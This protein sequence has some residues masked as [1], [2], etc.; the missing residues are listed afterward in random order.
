MP[1][2]IVHFDIY[3]PQESA[4]H[5]FYAD[6]FGWTVDP[7]GPGYALVSTPA[8][9]PDGALVEADAA[10]VTIGIAV[11]DLDAAVARAV[12]AGGAVTMP[13]TDNGWIVKAQ[14]TDPAG[15]ALTLIQR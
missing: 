6:L 12:D 9:G 7:K 15:N 1:D 11:D 14:V 5:R 2:P 8:G 10:A 4:Q 13:P 3:G